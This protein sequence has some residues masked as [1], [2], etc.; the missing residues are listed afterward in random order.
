MTPGE[1]TGLLTLKHKVRESLVQKESDL[2]RK[3]S[4]SAGDTAL[5][6]K[7]VYFKSDLT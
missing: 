6:K 3:K 5:K 1:D 2:F 7:I 4:C